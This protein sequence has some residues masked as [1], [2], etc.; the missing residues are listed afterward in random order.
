MAPAAGT[1]T[2]ETSSGTAKKP[3][4][5]IASAEHTAP[6]GSIRSSV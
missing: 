4:A 1:I 6:S 5:V 2:A 3:S